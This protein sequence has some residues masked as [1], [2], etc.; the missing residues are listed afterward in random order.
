MAS[1]EFGRLR[2]N[3][4]AARADEQARVIAMTDIDEEVGAPRSSSR[5]R[6]QEE[7]LVDD[8]RA[9]SRSS[10]RNRARASE[11][12]GSDRR[13]AACR[14]GSHSIR[15]WRVRRTSPSQPAHVG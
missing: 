2:R 8:H 4:D 12:Q 14:S 11:P 5:N 7:F 9:G 13:P 15:R 3:R 1:D 10:A 6:W